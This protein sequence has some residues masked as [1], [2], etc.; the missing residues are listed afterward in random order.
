MANFIV[1]FGYDNPEMDRQLYE[2]DRLELEGG[3]WEY[4][5][6]FNAST[7]FEALIKAVD[8]SNID[9]PILVRKVVNTNQLLMNKLPCPYI[10]IK[11]QLD[12]A[13]IELN[14]FEV[15]RDKQ[16]RLYSQLIG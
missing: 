6:D 10:V 16:N 9:L 7:W 8:P 13:G 2:A 5:E 4:D 15:K 11:N 12:R 3:K 14:I 1:R